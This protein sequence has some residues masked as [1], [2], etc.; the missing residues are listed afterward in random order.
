M[1][2]GLVV[3]CHD[4]SEGGLAVAL[5]EM[6]IGGR[7]GARIDEL[8]T[9]DTV[10]ALFSESVGRLVVEV[11]PGDVDRFVAR[12]GGRVTRLGTVTAEPLLIVPGLDELAVDELAA[13]FTGTSGEAVAT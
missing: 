7:L 12:L 1:R 2:D 13:I 11:A 8:P 9:D 10:T 3:A 4:V 5:A 6:C